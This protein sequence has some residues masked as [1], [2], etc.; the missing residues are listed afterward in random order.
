MGKVDMLGL[1]EVAEKEI[2]CNLP[3]FFE[4]DDISCFD[5]G[6]QICIFDTH[7]IESSMRP[8]D[9]FR[10]FSRAYE[11]DFEMMERFS[12]ELRKFVNSWY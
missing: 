3:D 9:R 12:Y 4:V 2:S 11:S 8:A 10:F 1:V 7:S 5:E 6:F